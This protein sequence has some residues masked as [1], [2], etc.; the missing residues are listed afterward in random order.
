MERGWKMEN[1]QEMVP[2]CGKHW[3]GWCKGEMDKRS[4]RTEDILMWR[5]GHR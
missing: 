1:K 3:G 4:Y 2:D 5:R